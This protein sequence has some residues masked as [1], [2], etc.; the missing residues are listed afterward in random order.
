MGHARSVPLSPTGNKGVPGCSFGHA[1]SQ[2]RPSV[3]KPSQ[4]PVVT[5]PSLSGYFGRG[6]RQAALC[7]HCAVMSKLI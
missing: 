5:V 3:A 6:H 1:V 4:C 7:A 2:P